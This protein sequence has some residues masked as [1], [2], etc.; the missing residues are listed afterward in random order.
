MSRR[1]GTVAL[2]L[3]GGLLLFGVVWGLLVAAATLVGVVLLAG[4]AGQLIAGDRVRAGLVMPAGLAGVVVAL[5]AVEWLR[6]PGLLWLAG[7]PVLWAIAGATV[8][9]VVSGAVASR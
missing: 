5:L 8:A 4:L 3:L 2:A 6:L 1:S 7:V 9:I